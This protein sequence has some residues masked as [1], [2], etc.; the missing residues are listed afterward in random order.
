MHLEYYMYLNTVYI[1]LLHAPIF[2][3]LATLNVC[4]PLS[5]VYKEHPFQFS[6]LCVKYSQYIINKRPSFHMINNDFLNPC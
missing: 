3:T 5:C 6:L 1:L 4:C 2:P